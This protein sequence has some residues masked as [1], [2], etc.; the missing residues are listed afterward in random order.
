MQVQSQQVPLFKD[1]SDSPAGRVADQQEAAQGDEGDDQLEADVA[2]RDRIVD[3]AA[4]RDRRDRDRLVQG[5]RRG[6]S[7]SES[8]GRAR[9]S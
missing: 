9:L 2:S 1:P 8:F 5:H 6:L 3:I 4:S 7:S